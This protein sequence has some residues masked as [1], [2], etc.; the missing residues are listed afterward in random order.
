MPTV[1]YNGKRI[2]CD[3]GERLR[4]VLL[5]ADLSVHNGPKAVS[6]HG[7]GS[8]GTCAVEIEGDAGELSRRERLRLSIPPHDPESG[9]RLSCQVRV[10][11][12]LVV[13]KYE[14]F[15]GEQIESGNS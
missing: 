6:C 4:D 9:L 1:E 12:D 2:D 7:H 14:G 10:T 5:A 3:S 13:E 11:D 8:C 15:W